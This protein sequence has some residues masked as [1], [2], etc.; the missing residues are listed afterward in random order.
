MTKQLSPEAEHLNKTWEYGRKKAHMIME[1]VY[2][3][4]NERIEPFN[5]EEKYMFWMGFKKGLG[6]IGD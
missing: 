1:D 4:L 3:E 5:P 6:N 2:Q